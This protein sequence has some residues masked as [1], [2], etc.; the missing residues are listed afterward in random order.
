MIPLRPADHVSAH[1]DGQI[2]VGIVLDVD[3]D[4]QTFSLATDH[5]LVVGIPLDAIV[6]VEPVTATVARARR[7]DPAHPDELPVTQPL[8]GWE[9]VA[10]L[11]VVVAT[12][13]AGVVTA[14]AL[15]AVGQHVYRWLT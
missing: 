8:G 10:A 14:A 12:V 4:H 11:G 1:H 9:L 5:G 3:R 6:A 13:A 15:L 2:L 7:Y